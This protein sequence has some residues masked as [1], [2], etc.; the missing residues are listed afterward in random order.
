MATGGTGDILT[1][2]IAGLV[3]QHPPAEKQPEQWK[4]AVAAAVWL[5][6]R[7]G[8]LAGQRLGEGSMLAL[9]RL[10]SLPEA[11]NQLRK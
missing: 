1:G 8:E 4:Q 3:A 10:D 2:M 9:D 11:I 7:C 5:H 6:G